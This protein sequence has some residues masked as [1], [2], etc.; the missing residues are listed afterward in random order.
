MNDPWDIKSGLKQQGNTLHF[1]TEQDVEPYLDHNAAQRDAYTPY[2]DRPFVMA[3]SIPIA[4]YKLLLTELGIPHERMYRLT[5]EETQRR[6]RLLETPEWS[7]LKT[8]PGRIF[9]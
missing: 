1:V 6:N 4:A 5:P 3:A 9:K 8:F 2:K 7:A